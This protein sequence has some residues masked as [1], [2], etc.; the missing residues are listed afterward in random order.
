MKYEGN[1]EHANAIMSHIKYLISPTRLG[2]GEIVSVTHPV[3][4]V[5]RVLARA[6]FAKAISY[7]QRL[8]EQTQKDPTQMGR[9]YRSHSD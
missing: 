3:L 4:I 1:K 7:N 6:F 5:A 9:H 8:I 2:E